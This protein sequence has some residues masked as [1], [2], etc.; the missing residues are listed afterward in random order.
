LVLLAPPHR[1]PLPAQIGAALV[2]ARA[3]APAKSDLLT[4]VFACGNLRARPETRM[5]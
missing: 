4:R 2:A 1:H 5:S 3:I